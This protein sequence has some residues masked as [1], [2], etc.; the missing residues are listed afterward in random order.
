M[1]GIT[2][3]GDI[4][5]KPRRR[6]NRVRWCFRQR[7]RGI[8]MAVES[9]IHMR[10]TTATR[11]PARMQSNKCSSSSTS[12]M[13]VAILP[14]SYIYAG[15][16]DMYEP[17]CNAIEMK[18]GDNGKHYAFPHRKRRRAVRRGFVRV[19]RH[20]DQQI[21]L[22]VGVYGGA[23]SFVGCHSRLTLDH[24]SLSR[25]NDSAGGGVECH[26]LSGKKGGAPRCPHAHRYPKHCNVA[27]GILIG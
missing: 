17:E 1:T 11:T 27:N 19:C 10:P 24:A 16:G 8:R 13:P 20:Q 12:M 7:R 15:L 22:K 3:C 9:W 14:C 2:F 21:H 26:L 18:P 5:N 6:Y 25:R 4:N 23:Y